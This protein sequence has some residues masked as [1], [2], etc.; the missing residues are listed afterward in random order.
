VASAE[1]SQ[2]SMACMAMSPKGRIRSWM[3]QHLGARVCPPGRAESVH[4]HAA[5]MQG[6]LPPER[7]A[8]AVMRAGSMESCL[9]Q[10]QGHPRKV[11]LGVLGFL[12]HQDVGVLVVLFD[13]RHKVA[14]SCD[15]WETSRRGPSPVRCPIC[16]SSSGPSPGKPSVDSKQN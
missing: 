1:V 8:L 6:P 12:K 11:G 5:S 3:L 9:G 4:V 7:P 2:P 15:L 16:C 10:V 14:E 13:G